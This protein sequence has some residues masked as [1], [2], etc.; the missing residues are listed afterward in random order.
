MSITEVSI[1]RLLPITVIFVTLIM[2]GFVGY[3]QL[4][5]NLLPKFEAN[6]VSVRTNYRGASPEEHPEHDHQTAGR[7]G[8]LIDEGVDQTECPSRR[9]VF[10][11]SPSR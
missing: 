9:K 8:E 4:S 1:K 2:F 3:K 5:Y 7:C 11:P 6:V 10:P